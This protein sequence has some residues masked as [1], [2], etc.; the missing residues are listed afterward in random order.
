MAIPTQ[1]AVPLC[2]EQGDTVIFTESFDDFPTT[3]GWSAYLILARAG[4]S[5]VRFDATVSSE[6]FLWTISSALSAGV[7]PGW[8]NYAIYVNNSTQRATAKSGRLS[9]LDNLQVDQPLSFA[10]Q[11][12]ATLQTALASLASS[13]DASVSFN[14]QSF[15]RSGIDTYKN[16]LVYWESRVI[17]E[18]RALDAL[19]GTA[20]DNFVGTRFIGTV[21]TPYGTQFQIP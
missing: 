8:W 1:A 2:F 7:A 6:K 15:S 13:T 19:R 12:V 16:Q 21:T 5:P 14:G 20:R 18:Q 3:G 11:Q 17:S 4:A 10:Q 9:V